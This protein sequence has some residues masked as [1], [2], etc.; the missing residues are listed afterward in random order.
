MQRATHRLPG[1]VLTEHV[2]DLPLDHADPS[3]R[4]IEVFA[5]EVRRPGDGS[6]RPF[7]VFLQ[8]G[9]GF[10]APRPNQ[11]GGWLERALEDHRVLLID[12]RGTGRSTA[13]DAPRVTAEGDAEAQA[14]Y[15]AHFRSDSIV[16]DCEAVRR[17]LG[18]ERWSLLGQSYGGFCILRYLSAAPEGLEAA[19]IAGGVPSLYATAEDI[20]RRT[21]ELCKRK[22]REYYAR[23]PEDIARVRAIAEHLEAQDV[24]LPD[25]DPLS[26]RRFQ[27]LGLQL[28]F[29]DGFETVH[30]L[31]EDAFTHG[32][33]LS[34]T[35]L[36]GVQNAQAWDT[37]PIF[38]ALHEACYTQGT[39]SGWAAERLLAEHPEFTLEHD[40]PLHLTGEMVYPFLFDEVSTLRPLREA[41]HIL[42]AKEDWPNLYDPEQLARNTVPVAAAVYAND[43][44]VERELSMETAE[45]VA[46]LRTWVTD[47]YEHNGLRA[48]GGRVLGRL[49]DLVRGEA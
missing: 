1:L 43:M 41:A 9:P 36:R 34:H 39:A 46:G 27:T 23:Y 38:S 20:Y 26:L 29:S 33:A 14:R 4:T 45:R 42:A 13:I 49:M 30:Y 40:G 11:R 6:D 25:G 3:G 31:V 16:A 5:R 28:G 10:G 35:F 12:E 2:F 37:N 8:G 7:L 21:Y 24:R 17:E 47:E 48:D 18:V 22:N 15:L 19:Y 32:G 44:Y